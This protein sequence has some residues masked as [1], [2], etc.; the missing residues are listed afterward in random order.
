MTIDQSGRITPKQTKK[1]KKQGMYAQKQTVDTLDLL[2]KTLKFRSKT[3]KVIDLTSNNIN[4]EGGN[5]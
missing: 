3:P 4:G 5:S 1:L 2:C